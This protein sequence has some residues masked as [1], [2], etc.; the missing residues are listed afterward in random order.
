MRLKKKKI[1]LFPP[2]LKKL[3]KSIG[4]HSDATFTN[5]FERG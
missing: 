5:I 3:D 1:S 2:D 4:S